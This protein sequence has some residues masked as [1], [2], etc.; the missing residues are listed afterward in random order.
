[1]VAGW[2][3]VAWDER[4]WDG[5]NW[6]ELGWEMGWDERGEMGRFGCWSGDVVSGEAKICC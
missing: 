1:M 2:D 6:H 4:E 3:G 5:M